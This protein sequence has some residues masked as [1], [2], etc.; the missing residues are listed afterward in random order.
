MVSCAG[1]LKALPGQVL[2]YRGWSAEATLFGFVCHQDPLYAA[3][4]Y[5]A[6]AP[7]VDAVWQVDRVYSSTPGYYYLRRAIPLYD[8]YVGRGVGQDLATLNATVSHVVAAAPELA[9]PG[10]SLEREIRQRPHP[11]PGCRRAA[12]RP[13]AG[14]QPVIVFDLVWQTMQQIDADFPAPPPRPRTPRSVSPPDRRRVAQRSC[15]RMDP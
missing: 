14:T 15:R 9:I 5:L 1:M 3:C 13:V 11:A 4:R 8:A 6:R 10:Y 12:G 7:G 2:A